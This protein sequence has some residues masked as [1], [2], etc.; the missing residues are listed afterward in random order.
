MTDA[1]ESALSQILAIFE[2]ILFIVAGALTLLGLLTGGH[3]GVRDPLLMFAAVVAGLGV[4]LHVIRRR[5][6]SP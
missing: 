2:I 3:M 1:R 4:A 6:V 5:I